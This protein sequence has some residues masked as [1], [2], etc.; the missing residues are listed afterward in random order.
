MVREVIAISAES[1]TGESMVEFT[2]GKLYVLGPHVSI[3]CGTKYVFRF[4]IYRKSTVVIVHRTVS[5]SWCG[6]IH[7]PHPVTSATTPDLTPIG[8]LH[9]A[10]RGVIHG[11]LMGAP[12]RAVQY[13]SC[14][15][16]V[17]DSRAMWSHIHN[18]TYVIGGHKTKSRPPK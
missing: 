13:I 7:T 17:D 11:C 4:L 16:V 5:D 18:Y 1:S 2:S 12:T 3:R 8:G 15:S 9:G 14:A 10:G 6:I